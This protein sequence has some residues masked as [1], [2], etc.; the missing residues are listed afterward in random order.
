M[1]KV[2]IEDLTLEIKHITIGVKLA[3]K[4]INNMVKHIDNNSVPKEIPAFDKDLF[5]RQTAK[6]IALAIPDV[7]QK[8]T[9]KYPTCRIGQCWET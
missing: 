6:C 1:N 7:K 8:K 3:A 5:D 4:F 2:E 9:A